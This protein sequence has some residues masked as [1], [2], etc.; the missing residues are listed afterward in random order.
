MREFVTS[1]NLLRLAVVASVSMLAGCQGGGSSGG[2]FSSNGSKGERPVQLLNAQTSP[3]S[4]Q[5]QAG[6]S[7]QQPSAR[8]EFDDKKLAKAVERYRLNKKQ[9]QSPYRS[10]GY[11]LDG[12]G[13]AEILTLLEGAD[14]CAKTGCTLAIF[15]P[16][17]TG[18]RPVA[19]IRRVW[20]PVSITN[21]R[22]N[23][24]SDLVVNT[25]LPSRDQRVRLR[26]GANGYPGNA[27]TLTPMPSDIEIAG[28]VVLE[29]IE[30]MPQEVVA[31]TQ[32]PT[33]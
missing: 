9:K 24:W 31:N 27:V 13:E 15:T 7:E 28:E 29:R 16:G 2:L 12:D 25:G 6:V 33:N 32:P 22:N 3:T 4:G 1:R 11:D 30:M 20:G 18:Y 26:F 21:E 19:T 5:P 10:V 23:G 8:M 14:W 17:K